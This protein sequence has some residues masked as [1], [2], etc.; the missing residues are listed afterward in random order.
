MRTC[1]WTAGVADGLR[2]GKS[3]EGG[4]DLLRAR[5]RTQIEALVEEYRNGEAEV[6]PSDPQVCRYCHLPRPVPRQCLRGGAVTSPRA[7]ADAEH[8]AAALQPEA[9]CIVQAPA[10]SGKTTLLVNR[11]AA[12]LAGVEKPEQILAITFTRKAA[13]EMRQRVLSLLDDEQD[14]TAAAIRARDAALGWR[15]ADNPSRLQIQTIDSFAMSLTGRLPLAS[16]FDRRT[17]LVEDGAPPLRGSRPPSAQ[18]AV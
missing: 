4:W 1:G 18:P 14:A 10:G 2:P 6:Q 16:G 8:R 5:W 3:P 15:L 7:P 13:A 11:F 12:L 9:S 17:R